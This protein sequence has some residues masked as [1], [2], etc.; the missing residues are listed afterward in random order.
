MA[1]DELD[2]IYFE[3]IPTINFNG[4]N[5]Y[6]WS[7]LEKELLKYNN[8]RIYNKVFRNKKNQHC[9]KFIIKDKNQFLLARIKYGF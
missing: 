1:D 3:L 5:V 2:E 6:T 7:D 9:W 8:K 4:F